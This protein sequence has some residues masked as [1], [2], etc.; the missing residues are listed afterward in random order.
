MKNNKILFAIIGLGKIGLR[1]KHIIDNNANFELVAIIDLL[2]KNLVNKHNNTIPFFYDLKSFFKSKIEVDIIVISTPNGLHATQALES[3]E[4]NCHVLVEK[5]MTLIKQDAENIISKS[6]KVNKNVFVVMQNRYS[7]PSAWIK[8]VV[9]Q[10]I[11]GEIYLVQLNCFW[12][13]DERYYEGHS[14]HGSKELDGGTLYTQFSHFIDMIYWLFGDIKNIKSKFKNFNHINKID[15]EDTGLI[16]FDFYNGGSGSMSYSTSVRDENLES[17]LT[18]IAENGTVKIGGQYM[19][20]VEYCNIK[21]YVMPTLTKSNPPNDYGDYKG[22]A[23][24]HHYVYENI[25]EVLKNNTEIKTNALEGL[26]V[27]EIIQNIYNTK[28]YD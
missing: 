18:I 26:K 20:K 27:T 15:F 7:P 17:S 13:R 21:D 3:L 14:W 24:N 8:E 25:L 9:E 6:I 11:L 23:Q 19:D 28:N 2:E 12:N 16:N 1:H 5:P 4:N 10:K 22:S